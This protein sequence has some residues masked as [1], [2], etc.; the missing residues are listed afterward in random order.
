MR[1]PLFVAPLDNGDR[2]TGSIVRRPNGTPEPVLHLA[3][4]DLRP[5]VAQ[6]FAIEDACRD[7]RGAYRHARLLDWI[8]A[9]PEQPTPL[10]HGGPCQGC[11]QESQ[12]LFLL[13]MSLGEC[14]VE[15]VEVCASCGRV[16]DEIARE[17]A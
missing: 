12:Q 2:I 6:L 14:E 3:W 16:P 10:E 1:D 13:R 9:N 11:G 7:A 8:E 5:S 4:L 17:V 15:Y